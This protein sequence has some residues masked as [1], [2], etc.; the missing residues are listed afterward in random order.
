M[1]ES[2]ATTDTLG[3]PMNS[4]KRFEADDAKAERFPKD[5]GFGARGSHEPRCSAVSA[6]EPAPEQS[7]W[8]APLIGPI[9]PEFENALASRPAISDESGCV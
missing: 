2:G 6:N 9:D 1:S 3:D 5:A 8:L 4:T 7:A